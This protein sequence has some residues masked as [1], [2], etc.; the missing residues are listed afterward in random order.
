MLNTAHIRAIGLGNN[1]KIANIDRE[2]D[3]TAPAEVAAG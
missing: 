2:T 3:W 1:I